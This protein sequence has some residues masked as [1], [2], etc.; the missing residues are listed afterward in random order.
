MSV[1]AL[2]VALISLTLVPG[3]SLLRTLGLTSDINGRLADGVAVSFVYG[4]VW[5]S[6]IGLLGLWLDVPFV[7]LILVLLVG[8]AVILFVAM[9]KDG[10]RFPM[11]ISGVGSLALLAWGLLALQV[12]G[13][14]GVFPSPELSRDIIAIRKA[15]AGAGLLD[16]AYRQ[17]VAAYEGMQPA[18]AV[19]I[20]SAAALARV[21]AL[22]AIEL[23]RPWWSVLSLC[24]SY[25]LFRRVFGSE[26]VASF[27]VAWI[28]A[29]S[30]SVPEVARFAPFGA[31]SDIGLAVLLPAAIL[32]AVRLL[33]PRRSSR[34][35]W[36]MA[37]GAVAAFRLASAEVAMGL[38]AV[39]ASALGL[40]IAR[41]SERRLVPRV[42]V[43]FA[44][45]LVLGVLL[46]GGQ[47]PSPAGSS[48]APAF[49]LLV[50]AASLWL[51]G[52][53]GLRPLLPGAALIVIVWQGP[54]LTPCLLVLGTG[55]VAAAGHRLV[56][57]AWT[58]STYVE[59]VAGT[60][61]EVRFWEG[62]DPEKRADRAPSRF[63]LRVPSRAVALFVLGVVAVL[64]LVAADF[65]AP[66]VTPYLRV[67]AAGLAVL[68]IAVGSRSVGEVGLEPERS[69]AVAG[70]VIVIGVAV[71][72]SSGVEPAGPEMRD[73]GL[74]AQRTTAA[75]KTSP[76][77]LA[78]WVDSTR[79]LD[80]P[81]ALLERLES[82]P[83]GVLAYP[84]E[85][86]ARVP[87]VTKHY[88]PSLGRYDSRES[89]LVDA[90]ARLHELDAPAG[91]RQRF[92]DETVLP[93]F[94]FYND[95]DPPSLTEEWLDELQID[96]IIWN[97]G[98]GAASRG[99]HAVDD[100]SHRLEEIERRFRFTL[101]R[102]LPD[103]GAART[104]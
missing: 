96:Y 58:L 57:D 14:D 1:A 45:T 12:G 75:A 21:E 72:L 60:A 36:L 11:R 44:L 9:R 66:A 89:R 6:A 37:L 48:M 38:V 92:Y 42:A 49:S 18:Y 93:R 33:E 78:Q 35:T 104:E 71:Y 77:P 54:Q 76:R 59:R 65:Y 28:L 10:P 46:P 84:P 98:R 80:V 79:Y 17:D 81:P 22:A 15:S 70:A 20:A 90:F 82:L 2:G 5:P 8:S 23:L 24:L 3:Y 41:A 73:Q 87:V 34:A 97:S 95:L 40:G 68:R 74:L 69:F 25:A 83:T 52:G 102:V 67:A 43:L 51:L 7:P 53:P 88:V 100:L 39:L 62:V 103:P 47:T 19:L 55:V 56:V 32:A 31:S 61:L 91:D 29:L 27:S 64:V 63:E 86:I 13:I 101:Y 4:F 16:L 26:P 99:S 50:A 94:P 85:R 30:L